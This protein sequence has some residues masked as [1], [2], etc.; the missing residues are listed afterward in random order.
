M[1][2]KKIK[3]GF[4]FRPNIDYIRETMNMPTYSKLK[5]LE[6]ANAFIDKALSKKK[7]RAWEKLK[8]GEI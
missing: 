2:K 4:A 5:W 8:R 6:E 7:K 1:R 3:F